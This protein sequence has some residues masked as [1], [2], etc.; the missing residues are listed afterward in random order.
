VNRKCK[1]EATFEATLTE[2]TFEATFG[3]RKC[4]DPDR[5]RLYTDFLEATFQKKCPSCLLPLSGEATGNF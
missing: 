4:E 3:N 2:A 5:E 1:K